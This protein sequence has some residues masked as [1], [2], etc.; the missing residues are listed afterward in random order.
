MGEIV[1]GIF[2]RLAVPLSRPLELADYAR[3]LRR[4]AWLL[5]VCPL[6]AGLGAGVASKAM[7][8]I[9]EANATVLVRPSQPLN[10]DLNQAN[11]GVTSTSDQISA[12][13]AQLMTQPTLLNKVI[14]DLHLR[15]TPEAL[16]SSVK[17]TPES[18]TTV[19]KVAV[20]DKDP[21]QARAIANTLVR[22]FT[23]SQSQLL[24]QRLGPQIDRAEGQV[25]QLQGVVAA[26]QAQ[27]NRIIAQPAGAQLSQQDQAKLGALQQQLGT[28]NTQLQNAQ[29][30]LTQLQ[31]QAAVTSDSVVVVSP[32][33]VP[34]S[35]VWPK[36]PLNVLL[37]VVAGLM[38][39]LGLV[40]LI[41]RLDQTVKDDAELQ[42]RVNLT[43][44][45]HIP[46]TAAGKTRMG[47]LL[48]LG[49][50][51]AAS[52]AYRNLRTNLLFA[53]V[54]RKVK[55]IV[56]TSAAPGEGKSRTAV[57]LAAVLAAAGH[58]TL[59]IDADFRRPS[60]HRLFA[61]V[62]QRGLSELILNG[63]K[64]QEEPLLR[65]VA[66]VPRLWLLA[67]GSSPPNP[68]ELLGSIRMRALLDELAS[69]FDYV[70][71]D[72][73]PLN[74]VT[75]P[76]LVAAQADATLVVIEQGRTTFGAIVNAKNQLDNVGAHVL[77]AV[78]N[79]VRTAGGKYGYP[80]YPYYG[81]DGRR[82]QAAA[83]DG[84]EAATSGAVAPR[85]QP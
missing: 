30:G 37:A 8:P 75:D 82:S 48:V 74:A 68:S 19:I 59:I 61:R 25:K 42:R 49:S 12:T 18:S 77:G 9:Y 65:E 10:S 29:T 43:P 5:V 23:A 35:P 81:H 83:N 55:T 71:L 84:E 31:T 39:G 34:K 32:A 73:P 66:E 70:V 67:A 45:G 6:V 16:A 51:T 63:Q 11:S 60:L 24:Q 17:V 26:D 69:R 15:T 2:A 76:A 54:D 27:I 28:D 56:I 64:L 41:E 53:S 33:S 47:E 79:K 50:A 4:W 21:E 1:Q 22:D 80:A 58:Q 14:S 3:Q 13:Y 20:Q 38:V 52:E 7:T 72:T 36:T 57:N 46:F 40:L 78:V 62:S 85:G 44:L